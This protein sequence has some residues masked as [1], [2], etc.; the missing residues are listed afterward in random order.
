MENNSN[1]NQKLK[2]PRNLGPFM[3]NSFIKNYVTLW[4]IR[5]DLLEKVMKEGRQK[6]KKT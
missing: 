4:E 3:D 2:E 5:F 6:L 1:K